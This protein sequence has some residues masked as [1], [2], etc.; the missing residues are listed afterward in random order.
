MLIFSH[1]GMPD[2]TKAILSGEH[3]TFLNAIIPDL[4]I[5]ENWGASNIAI[6]CNT[7][8]Y[9]YDVIQKQINIPIIHMP[10]ESV[11]TA[12]AMMG[13]IKMQRSI[14]IMATDGTVQ[15]GIYHRECEAL[16]IR[17][18]SPSKEAQKSVMSLIYDDIKAGRPGD[19]DK[20][21]TAFEDLKRQGSDMVILACTEISVFKKDNPVPGICLDAMD[22][23][24]KESIVRSGGEYI[25]V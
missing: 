20:F 11:R 1:A 13:D 14:G 12:A 24:V 17:P 19:P 22:V 23:L 15:A 8:H 6:P 16:G 18:V 3:E 4:R 9:F 25:P 2:R 7:S 10:R 21:R 5:L